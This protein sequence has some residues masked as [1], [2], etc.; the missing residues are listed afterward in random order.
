M[1]LPAE[2]G[3]LTHEDPRIP[4]GKVEPVVLWQLT[5]GHPDHRVHVPFAAKLRDPEGVDDVARGQ[6]ERDGPVHRNVKLVGRGDAQLRVVEAPPVPLTGDLHDHRPIRWRPL[7]LEDALDGGNDDGHHDQRRSDG[8]RDLQPHVT[9]DLLRPGRARP[10]PVADQDV[11]QHRPDRRQ[12]QHRPPEDCDV[13]VLRHV[14]EVRLGRDGGLGILLG[15]GRQNRDRQKR[16]CSRGPPLEDGA[17]HSGHTTKQ[18]ASTRAHTPTGSTRRISSG[19]AACRGLA[20]DH[21]IRCELKWVRSG[22]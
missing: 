17:H 3:A 6:P 13:Q 2:L 11:G 12:N 10:L 4:D 9:V 5:L 18:I 8:P 22:P 20:L 19:A 21:H 15:A 1:G 14:S 7:G 16:P